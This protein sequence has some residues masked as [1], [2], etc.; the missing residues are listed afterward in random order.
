LE[1]DGDKPKAV[2]KNRPYYYNRIG[3]SNPNPVL[4]LILWMFHNMNIDVF[5]FE[6]AM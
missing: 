1:Q 4:A 2:I 6:H 3:N 5:S